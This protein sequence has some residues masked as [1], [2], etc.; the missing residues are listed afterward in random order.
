MRQ[1]SHYTIE[2]KRAAVA[3]LMAGNSARA[4]ERATGID[5]HLLASWRETYQQGGIAAL[6]NYRQSRRYSPALKAKVVAEYRRGIASQRELC[7]KYNISNPGLCSKW[8]NER[9]AE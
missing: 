9:R 3:A 4:V 6:A 7:R 2:D 5:H 8:V 1:W